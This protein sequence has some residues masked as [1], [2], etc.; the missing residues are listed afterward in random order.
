M[1]A[2]HKHHIGLYFLF[3]GFINFEYEI[4]D[5]CSLPTSRRPME[6]DMGDFIGSIEIVEF[7]IDIFMYCEVGN[8]REEVMW[9]YGFLWYKRAV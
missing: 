9:L 3:I 7:F 8:G 6:N 1:G 5:N 2:I 4:V